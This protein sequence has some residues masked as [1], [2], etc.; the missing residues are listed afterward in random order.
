MAPFS[1]T[2]HPLDTPDALCAYEHT[3]STDTAPENAIVFLGGLGDGPH[4]IPY[5]RTLAL[6]LEKHV[7]SY[8]VFELR[9]RSS[10]TA[11]GYSS[12][13]DDVDDIALLLAYLR[14]KLGRKKV[15]LIG[16][17]TGCQVSLW[18]SRK[19][20]RSL[21]HAIHRLLGGRKAGPG[22]VFVAFGA[23]TMLTELELGRTASSTQAGIS[24]G[25]S[26]PMGSCSKAQSR[27]ARPS[28]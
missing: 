23:C 5:V 1:V 26:R 16:H 13:D 6:Y 7:P 27:I 11:F 28:P 24:Q 3:T 4:T 19:P 17:S 25:V 22:S 2:V 20:P 9:M 18:R 12:L 14:S 15:V 21:G 8:S 10:F